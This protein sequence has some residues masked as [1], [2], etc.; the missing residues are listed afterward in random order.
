MLARI[1]KIL[2]LIFKRRRKDTDG[3][4]Y[5][6]YSQDNQ[7]SP[8]SSRQPERRQF[9]KGLNGSE[10]TEVIPLP[11]LKGNMLTYFHIGNLAK[12]C[13]CHG[14]NIGI[15]Q[16]DC[17]TGTKKNMNLYSYGK[18]D[19]DL[20]SI[21]GGMG[22]SEK[23]GILHMSQTWHIHGYLGTIG[24]NIETIVGKLYSFLCANYVHNDE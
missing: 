6:E 21:T 13:L 22:L 17:S 2:N 7:G 19:P 14:Y 11:P 15:W 24:V 3:S 5:S 10:E 18:A 1:K 20:N 4:E 23:F 8:R 12:E 9:S 16:L